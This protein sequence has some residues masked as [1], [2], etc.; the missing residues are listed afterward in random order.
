MEIVKLQVRLREDMSKHHLKEIRRGGGIPGSFYGKGKAALPLEIDIADLARALRT[1]AG[2]HAIIDLKVAGGGRGSGGTAVIKSIQKDPL[3]RK[4]LHVDF[5]RVSLSDTI[6]TQVVVEMH[7]DASGVREGGVL[8]QMMDQIEVRCRADHMP[9]RLDVDIS[10]LGI[11]EFI[12]ASAVPLPE[13]VELASRPDDIVAAVRM[14]HVHVLPAEKVAVEEEAV[15]E[16]EAP[17][18][19][20]ESG[21]TS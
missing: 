13:G 5:H 3:T 6:V 19:A 4:S 9:S 12:H 8:E 17:Q 1:E 11:G 7:G 10:N 20:E 14:P 18:P 2:I 15:A 16:P 21:K